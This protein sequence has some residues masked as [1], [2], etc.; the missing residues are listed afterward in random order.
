MLAALLKDQNTAIRQYAL[1][2]LE[3]NSSAAAGKAIAD[4]LME[5]TKMHGGTT[6]QANQL[7]N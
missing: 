7:P 1:R 3:M 5:T 2:A 4:V 6:L